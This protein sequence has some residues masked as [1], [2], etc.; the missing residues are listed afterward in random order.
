M[1]NT[2]AMASTSGNAAQDL[3]NQGNKQIVA[4]HCLDESN[5]G[6]HH[7]NKTTLQ[8]LLNILLSPDKPIDDFE[9]IEWC[10]WLMAGGRTPDE[11]F[12]TG[13]LLF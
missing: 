5:L 8:D 3:F 1:S 9:T 13:I 7:R 10:K 2:G 11:F 4:E 6:L 12:N